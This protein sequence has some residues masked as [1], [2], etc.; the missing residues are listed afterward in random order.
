M[1]DN[2]LRIRRF[3]PAAEKLLNLIPTD[4]GRPI[5]DLKLNLDCPDMERMITEVI[6][7]VSSREVETRDGAGRWH[8]LRVRPYR[9]LENKIDGAVLALVNIDESKQTELEILA[10]R[11]YAEAI[12][13][14]T[15]DPLLVLRADLTVESA[16]DAFYETFKT[17]PAE[18]EGRLIYELDV[19][20]WDIPELRLLLE[21]IIPRDDFFNDFEVTREFSSIGYRSMMLNARRVDS[22][23][24]GALSASCSSLKT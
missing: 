14:A 23:E 8:S 16:N 17:R 1:L 21:E 24:G 20:Q 5:G 6:D 15:R 9:T 12:I 19:R 3:T 13:A 22:R 2:Q 4:V 11:D 10:A 7:S 18:T